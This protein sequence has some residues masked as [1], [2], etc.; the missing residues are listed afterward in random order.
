MSFLPSLSLFLGQPCFKKIIS[1]T[2]LNKKLSSIGV[3]W[4][5]AFQDVWTANKQQPEGC[6]ELEACAAVPISRCMNLKQRCLDSPYTYDARVCSGNNAMFRST[7][8]RLTWLRRTSG[9]RY[10]ESDVNALSRDLFSRTLKPGSIL[11]PGIDIHFPIKDAILRRTRWLYAC[12]IRPS[13][14]L[15]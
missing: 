15:L 12:S 6:M 14:E 8:S 13:R 5:L 3:D 7:R 2:S 10:M 9:L 4:L 11:V 1:V